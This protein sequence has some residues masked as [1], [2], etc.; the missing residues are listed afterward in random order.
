MP[1]EQAAAEGSGA[2]GERTLTP[3]ELDRVAELVARMWRDELRLDA[4][5]RGQAATRWR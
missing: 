2:G 3:E 1:G 4:E 5:R